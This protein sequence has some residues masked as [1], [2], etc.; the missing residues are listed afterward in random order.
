MIT[1]EQVGDVA[2]YTASLRD[3]ANG[4][5]A[6]AK[7]LGDSVIVDLKLRATSALESAASSYR[8][9][10]AILEGQAESA[11]G[12][13]SVAINGVVA[14]IRKQI[15]DNL[16]TV[17]ASTASIGGTPY[18][19]MPFIEESLKRGDGVQDAIDQ[20]FVP[21]GQL[22]DSYDPVKP[23]EMR[24]EPTCPVPATITVNPITLPG[25]PECPAG[26][27]IN[28]TVPMPPPPPPPPP[29]MYMKGEEP[30]EPYRGPPLTLGTL[31]S[32]EEHR[33]YLELKLKLEEEE[34]RKESYIHPSTDFK[35]PDGKP[36]PPVAA[37]PEKKD[38]PNTMGMSVPGASDNQL[39]WS[40]L[41][42][43]ASLYNKPTEPF[44]IDV[45]KAE[46][47][48]DAKALGEKITGPRRADDGIGAGIFNAVSD[49]IEFVMTNAGEFAADLLGAGALLSG[50]ESVRD[51]KTA[52]S[53]T[54]ALSVM[55]WLQRLTAGPFDYLSQGR[56]YDLQH[57]A[58][59]YLPS[60]VEVDA[61]FTASKIDESLWNCWTRAHGNIPEHRKL[62]LPMQENRPGVLEDIALRN[63]GVINDETLNARLRANGVKSEENQNAY[64]E[65][66]RF[67]PGASDLI[68]FMLRDVFDLRAVEAGNYD[69]EFTTKFTN[70]EDAQRIA[71]ANGISEDMMRYFW[72]AHWNI[73]S[74][75]QLTECLHRLRE[76]RTPDG[77]K[78]VSIDQVREALK[79]DDMAPAW[80]E[81]LIAISYNP[82]TRTDLLQW[83]TNGSIDAKEVVERLQDT[84]YTA[85]DSQRIVDA[86][87]L[88]VRNRKSNRARTWT[89]LRITREYV[90]GTITAAIAAKL[91][92]KT[93]NSAEEIQSIIEEADTIRE[94]NSKKVCI[95]AMRKRYLQGEFNEEELRMELTVMGM[96]GDQ[97]MSFA[98]A[99]T[100][101]L[102][103]MDKQ[104]TIGMLKDWFHRGSIT[105]D[106]IYE[107]LINLRFKPPDAENIILSMILTEDE[108]RRSA[109][110]SAFNERLTQAK[111]FGKL[112]PKV[113]K[114]FEDEINMLDEIAD[115]KVKEAK[116]ARKRFSAIIGAETR[117]KNKGKARESEAAGGDFED[118]PSYPHDDAPMEGQPMALPLPNNRTEP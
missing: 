38:S 94:A 46:W 72:R 35:Q 20:I 58:P 71:K 87:D 106:E 85:A 66:A 64:K 59:Q 47:K 80:V 34:R 116:G 56:L 9:T 30:R 82:I 73:P 16:K 52:T 110:K 70:S 100:C 81:R 27:T 36:A 97:A 37:V 8:D 21:R 113:K 99:W 4:Y 33:L 23:F 14:R 90:D 92:A 83:F 57:S 29:R 69:D 76:G 25:T 18:T 115:A 7:A 118:A 63:R 40:N 68:R 43:C 15:D 108:R 74:Y 62:L 86:W 24:E 102:R 39:S 51:G 112:S 3:E 48:A 5:L 109:F 50:F 91:L 26:S 61:L 12:R 89:R 101:V 88:E 77:V 114:A 22:T 79:I 19:T 67:W 93:I 44:N 17:Y 10:T 32:E 54:I 95:K 78:P 117:A 31:P 41:E 98:R 1:M 105:K 49:L 103:S 53:S 65:L 28:I 2:T 60:Q 96:D 45:V 104:P 11:L 13:A 42:R 84:G 75:T 6:T 107:R 55:N 111:K